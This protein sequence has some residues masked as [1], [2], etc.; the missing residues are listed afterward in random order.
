[1]APKGGNSCGFC[2]FYTFNILLLLEGLVVIGVGIWL[3]VVCKNAGVIEILFIVLGLIEVLLAIL[4]Q[5]GRRSSGKLSC[6]IWSLG[7]IFLCQLVLTILGIT[8]K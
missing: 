5:H 6:Y 8:L 2:L 3:W 7:F 4:G 1:M